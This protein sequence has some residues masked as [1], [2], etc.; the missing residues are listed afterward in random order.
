MGL[1]KVVVEGGLSDHFLIFPSLHVLSGQHASPTYC[2]VCR[3][4]VTIG[5][6]SYVGLSV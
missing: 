4:G 6:C 2:T 5:G 3:P 1:V